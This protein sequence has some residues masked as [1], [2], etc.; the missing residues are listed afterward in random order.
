MTDI[1]IAFSVFEKGKFLKASETSITHGKLEFDLGYI[2]AIIPESILNNEKILV[3][4]KESAKPFEKF[5][6]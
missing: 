1:V 5:L 3:A 2:S 6:F 4:I